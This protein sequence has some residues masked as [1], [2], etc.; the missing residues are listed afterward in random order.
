MKLMRKDNQIIRVLKIKDEKVLLIDCVKR[1]MPVWKAEAELTGY[2]DC[3]EFELFE[4]TCVDIN[5]NL[6][7]TEQKI[8]R[9]R[10]TMIAG[11]LPF[12]ADQ[13]K[14]NEMVDALAI[15]NNCT[16]QTIRKYLCLYLVY[17]DI[18]VLAPAETKEKELTADQKNMRWSLNKF[19][20]T[21]EKHS[22]KYTYTM[23]LKEKYCD[24]KGKLLDTY[25]SYYQYRYFYRTHKN[26]QQFYISRDGIKHYQRENRP[27]LG[28]GVQQYCPT[29]GYSMLDSTTLDIYLVDDAGQ[30]IGRP[31]F[32]ICVDAFSGV[33][34]GYSLEWEGGMYTLR[35]MMMNV[36]AD[37]VDWCKK[38]NVFI[39]AEEWNTKQLPTT[40][41][42][43]MGSEYKSENLEQLTDLGIKIVNLQA[44]RPDLKGIV[45]TTFSSIQ[46]LFKSKLKGMGVV[47]ADHLERT[48]RDY[49]KD[50]CITMDEMEKV[51]LNCIVYF[52]SKLPVENY[53]YTEEMIQ[54]NVKPYRNEIY[55]W[56]KSQISANLMNIDTY[57]LMQVL[58]PRVTAKFTRKGLMVN[59][60][61][62]KHPNYVEDFLKGKEATVAYNPEDASIVWIIEN[63]CFV[64]FELIDSRFTGKSLDEVVCINKAKRQLLRNEVENN[65][66]ARIDLAEQI[67]TIVGSKKRSSN[68]GLKNI[69]NTRQR[70]RERCHIDF[71]KESVN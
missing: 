66:Q 29:V 22:L 17:Q 49:R 68:I 63:G 13:K 46:G 53:P 52:N 21:K 51:I 27:L 8:A 33:V 55:T 16:K 11:V 48:G 54:D 10:F 44:F 50:A 3:E 19:F 65:L 26:M 20:Y 58:L 32:T 30:V 47:D 39:K 18:S 56:G 12:I 24:S 2:V 43:D 31:I 61:R 40:L 57:H 64:P 37:K 36:V 38:K 4:L 59:G 1:T 62:Y 67:E 71:M 41:I 45:E 28:E 70:E 42:T 7:G 34:Q 5:R 69:R 15:D 9:E 35:S 23:M 6:N 60:L 14:R 25:P